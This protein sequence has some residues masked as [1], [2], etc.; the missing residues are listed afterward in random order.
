MCLKK[1][2][3]QNKEFKVFRNLCEKFIS[4]SYFMPSP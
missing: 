2:L 3:N 1:S 4:F